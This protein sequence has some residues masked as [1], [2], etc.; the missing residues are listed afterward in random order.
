MASAQ[1]KPDFAR[2]TPWR[3]VFLSTVQPAVAGMDT[4]ARASGHQPVAIITSQGP[5]GRRDEANPQRREFFNRL[6]WESPPDL[7]IAIAH[8]RSRLAPLLAAFDPDLVLCLGFPWRVP[9]DALAVPRLG[10]VNGHP[11]LLPRYRGP[12]PMAWAVRNGEMEL[13]M[14]YHRMD[15][16]FDT[17][18]V[19]AQGSIPLGEDDWI[20]DLQPRLGALSAQLLP[21]VFERLAA[22]DP[23]DPQDIAQASYAGFFEDEYS[24]VEWSQPAADLH[25][26]V[27]AWSFMFGY[28][29]GAVAQVDGRTI[30]IVRSRVERGAE[31]GVPG[32]VIRRDGDAVLVRCGEDALWVLETE[33]PVAGAPT[34][35]EGH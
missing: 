21:R 10:I 12:S 30:R 29:P 28:G 6:V 19:L 13:G 32:E 15:E 35:P 9:P 11:S 27:R 8:D 22:G 18:G 20:T 26:Q 4:F 33:E 25:R 3:I 31:E 16:D 17:G 5:Q 2:V 1:P 7:D 14:S 24:P 23:G 34:S